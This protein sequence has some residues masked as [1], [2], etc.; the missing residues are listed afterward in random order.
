MWLH[1]FMAVRNRICEKIT[2]NN[3]VI[4][5]ELIEFM[6]STLNFFT[7]FWWFM[8]IF[9]F[10]FVYILTKYIINTLLLFLYILYIYL[11]Q[12]D[13]MKNVWFCVFDHQNRN[14]SCIYISFF[15]I[16]RYESSRNSFQLQLMLRFVIFYLI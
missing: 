15:I 14:C 1:I 5:T 6:I 8:Y 11:H 12:S 3:N 7:N 4:T 10:I 9:Y 13:M 2:Q 16:L